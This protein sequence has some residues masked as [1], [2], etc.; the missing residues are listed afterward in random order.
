[1][2]GLGPI[3]WQQ[4]NKQ[5]YGTASDPEPVSRDEAWM[6]ADASTSI[7]RYRYAY[8]AAWHYY[9]MLDAINRRL[10]DPTNGNDHG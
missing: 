5:F 2:L 9:Q 8:P 3:L 6:I 10:A 7:P 4:I 1:M